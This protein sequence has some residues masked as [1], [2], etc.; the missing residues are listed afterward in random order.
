MKTRLVLLLALFG[1]ACGDD[2]VDPPCVGHG[3][4]VGAFGLPEAGEIRMELNNYADGT[5]NINMQALFFKSQTPAMRSLAGT[6]V[7]GS[8]EDWSSGDIFDNG[9]TSQGQAIADSREYVDVGASIKITRAG[10]E[11]TLARNMDMDDRTN[12][13][14]HDVVYLEQD[15]IDV[16]TTAELRAQLDVNADYQVTVPGLELRDGVSALGTELDAVNLYLAPDWQTLTPAVATSTTMVNITISAGQDSEWTWETAP[17]GTEKTPVFI[18]FINTDP[19]FDEPGKATHQCL[20]LDDSGRL[21]IPASFVDRLPPQGYILH[22]KFAHHAYVAN[23]GDSAQENLRR[24]DL[25]TI[26]CHFFSYVK[27]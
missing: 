26:N 21:V 15:H 14:R 19:N 18:A 13:L 23:F 9:D 6:V 7:A 3:C 4:E 20:D 12:F 27:Q 25:L 5:N 8:C 1:A 2:P 11:Y 17:S 24:L 22:G 16:V 10:R